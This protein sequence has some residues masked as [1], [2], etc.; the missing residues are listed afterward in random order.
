MSFLVPE[1]MY[2]DFE[3]LETGEVHKGPTG[4]PDRDE[5]CPVG[6][7]ERITREALI[8]KHCT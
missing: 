2:G 5:V 3:D 6:C 8:S 1:E 7:H 4:Q